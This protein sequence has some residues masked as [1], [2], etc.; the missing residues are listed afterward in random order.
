MKFTQEVEYVLVGIFIVQRSLLP[1][2]LNRHS[3]LLRQMM[4]INSIISRAMDP[5]AIGAP[6]L[7]L[8]AA[9]NDTNNQ[10]RISQGSNPTNFVSFRKLAIYIFF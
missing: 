4:A 5:P 1:R 3:L 2:L 6:A 7:N 8:A 10:T 9:E